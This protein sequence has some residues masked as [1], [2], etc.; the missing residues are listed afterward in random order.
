VEKG[1]EEARPNDGTNGEKKLGT[2]GKGVHCCSG[3]RDEVGKS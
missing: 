3:G 1:L 2:G